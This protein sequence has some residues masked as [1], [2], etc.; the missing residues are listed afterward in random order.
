MLNA[1]K[2]TVFI[3]SEIQ[4]LCGVWS[5][6]GIRSP[7][8]AYIQITVQVS[9]YVHPRALVLVCALY[10]LLC[11][12]HLRL[13]SINTPPLHCQNVKGW[14]TCCKLRNRCREVTLAAATTSTREKVF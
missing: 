1:L 6:W 5:S 8:F 12:Q 13:S 9:L 2:I 7:A 14:A 4:N 3:F 11:A 10:V